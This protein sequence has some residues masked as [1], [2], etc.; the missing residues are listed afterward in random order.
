[1]C[2][3]GAG[4]IASDL[5]LLSLSLKEAARGVAGAVASLLAL[6]SDSP[7]GPNPAGRPEL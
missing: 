6:G 7:P 2:A 1:M 4:G 3:C 5:S